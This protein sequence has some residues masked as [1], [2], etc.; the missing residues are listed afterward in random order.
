SETEKN[1]CAVEMRELRVL[2][3]AK[4]NHSNSPLFVSSLVSVSS[5][6]VRLRETMV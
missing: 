2:I 3:A 1:L 5:A 4:L 6:S